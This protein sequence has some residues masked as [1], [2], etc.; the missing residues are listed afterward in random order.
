MFD[1][2]T[3][4]LIGYCFGGF[5]TAYILGK[6]FKKIDI[7]NH[8]NGNL[9]ASNA[10]KIM[11]WKYGII[12]ALIDILKAVFAILLVKYIFND[13]TVLLFVAGVFTILGHVY[14]ILLKFK[15]GKGTASL[16]GMLLGINYK[17]AIIIIITIVLITIIT[18]YIALGTIVVVTMLP[19]LVY[20]FGYPM[21]AVYICLFI[22]IL[23][24][25]KHL[26][27]VKKII[28][29]EEPGLRGTLKKRKRG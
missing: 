14:P 15:G 27:N 26:P 24:I 13:S 25:F 20:V 17:I 29:K 8:G 7:R 3:A 18:D 28:R 11:G 6:I 5:Q 21:Q 1:Y 9:G 2:F 4:A 22:T 23:S 12:I 16:I 10:T 19:I